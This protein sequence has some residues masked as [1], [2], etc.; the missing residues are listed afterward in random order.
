MKSKVEA[1]QLI[2]S[3]LEELIKL[4]GIKDSRVVKDEDGSVSYIESEIGTLVKGDYLL[5]IDGKLSV[6]NAEDFN[7]NY[8]KEDV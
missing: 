7:F 1:I 8:V 3:N 4:S 6:L 2:D 5:K